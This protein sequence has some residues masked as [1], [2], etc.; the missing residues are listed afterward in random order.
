MFFRMYDLSQERG[1]IF[2][3]HFMQISVEKFRD[4]SIAEYAV[5]Y[6]LRELTKGKN[7]SYYTLTQTV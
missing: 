2:Y 4:H 1:N 5:L 6:F 3:N 7:K